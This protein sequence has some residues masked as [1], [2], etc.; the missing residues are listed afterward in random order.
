MDTL[1][2]IAYIK[3]TTGKIVRLTIPQYKIDSEGLGPDGN[4]VVHVTSANL[5]E[6]C[7]DLGYFMDNYWYDTGEH[8]FVFVGL[9]CNSHATW[10]LEKGW[11]DW[12]PELVK[13]DIR[14]T[15][16]ALLNACD[17]TQQLDVP[18]SE[19]KL[20]EWVTYRQQ[21]RDIT[22][23]ISDDILSVNDVVWPVQP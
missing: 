2:Y 20:Q 16:N 22:K 12:D 8:K 17:W 9:P 23:N 10:S 18:L 4:F 7:D 11:W 1:K 6:N 14:K 3:P 15:R 5:P 19:A 13:V 21:L